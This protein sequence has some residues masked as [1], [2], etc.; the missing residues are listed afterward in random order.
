[1]R[2]ITVII[3]IIIIIIIITTIIIITIIIK[4]RGNF[5]LYRF[6]KIH[7]SAY[8]IIKLFLS[9][10]KTK[11]FSYVQEKKLGQQASG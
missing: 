7:L 4:Y 5:P 2:I 6:Q 10:F 9:I 8:L 11:S 1:M 3:I